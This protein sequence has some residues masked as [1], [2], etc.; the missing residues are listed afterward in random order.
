MSTGGDFHQDGHS[1]GLSQ[2][3]SEPHE[4]AQGKPR[5][6]ATGDREIKLGYAGLMVAVCCFDSVNH[7]CDEGVTV[8]SVARCHNTVSCFQN[9]T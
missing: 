4:E 2:A 7:L 5:L 9:D 1:T 6:L 8:F 3:E